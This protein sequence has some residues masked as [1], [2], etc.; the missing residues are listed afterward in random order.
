MTDDLEELLSPSD[1]IP[2]GALVPSA[3]LVPARPLIAAEPLV[4]PAQLVTPL[5]L[6]PALLLRQDAL[7]LWQ[8]APA[9]VRR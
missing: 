8:D 6:V 2:A 3:E 7:A 9:E 1:P 5:Q 4:R